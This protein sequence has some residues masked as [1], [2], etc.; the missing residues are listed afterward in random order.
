[1]KT[2]ILD[3][4]TEY[5]GDSAEVAKKAGSAVIDGAKGAAVRGYNAAEDAVSATT[6]QI[7]RKPL[8]AV[9]GAIGAGVVSGFLIGRKGRG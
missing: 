5:L 9:L 4:T 3:R 6:R 8:V 2:A 1:M 7:R